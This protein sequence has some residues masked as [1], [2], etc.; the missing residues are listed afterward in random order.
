M[1]FRDQERWRDLLNVD[2][3]AT[4][5][6]Q[7][8]QLVGNEIRKT[9][10]QLNRRADRRGIKNDIDRLAEIGQLLEQHV[11]LGGN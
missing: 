2:P 4:T 6:E 8:R 10:N 7:L 5:A 1:D 9:C 3:T 11:W